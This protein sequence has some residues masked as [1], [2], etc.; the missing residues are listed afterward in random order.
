[1][2]LNKGD[3]DLDIQPLDATPKISC[4]DCLA[5]STPDT[6]QL[7][8]IKNKTPT[9]ANVMH[10]IS[11]TSSIPKSYIYIVTVLANLN[12]ECDDSG[13]DK[14]LSLQTVMVSPY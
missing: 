10:S 13:P 3:G 12:V 9:S 11:A 4:Q 5:D 8:P 1:M 7:A 2:Q 14:P 6:R